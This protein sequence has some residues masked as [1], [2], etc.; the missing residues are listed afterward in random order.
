[1]M[2]IQKIALIFI[3]GLTVFSCGNKEKQANVATTPQE[4]IVSE[5]V[6]AEVFQSKLSETDNVVI[7]DVRTPEEVADGYIEGAINIDF[8]SPD[9][10][11]AISELDKNTTYMVYCASG[12]RSGNTATL[13]KELKFK[14]VYDLKEGFK[15]WSSKGLPT[16]L[17]SN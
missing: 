7:L 15:G 14:E 5:V 9:F 17:P 6:S 10:Q 4:V 12:G 1:M 2:N 13:M 8:R 3:L 16:V 11:T